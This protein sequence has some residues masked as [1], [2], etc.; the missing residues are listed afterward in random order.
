MTSDDF[1]INHA[2]KNVWCAPEQD[3]QHILR[4]ARI[5]P[6]VGARGSVEVLWTRFNLPTAKE[7]YHVFQ[8]GNIALS[9]LDLDLKRNVWTAVS[10]QMV[11]SV[12]LIDIYTEKGLMIPRRLAYFLYTNDGNLVIAIENLLTIGDFGQENVYVR[13]YSNAFFDRDDMNDPSEGI[14]YHYAK[15]LTSSAINALTFKL[16]DLRLKS[17]YS[18]A[19]VNGWRVNELNVSTVATGDMVEIVRDSSVVRVEEWDVKDLPVFLSELD[20]KQKYL[21]HPAVNED[22]LI[23]YRD[24]QD[25]F[26]MYKKTPYV[27]KGVYYHKNVEDSVR[28]VTHRDYSIPTAQVD[29]FLNQ[30]PNWAVNSQLTVQMFIRRSGIDRTLMSEAHHIRELYKLEGADWQAA[31]MGTEAVVD[32]WRIEELEKSQ[33]TALMRAPSATITREMVEAA[34]GYNTITRIVAD[35]PQKISTPKAWTELPFGLRGESTVY[36]YDGDGRLLGWY[37]NQ[38]VQNYVPRSA[39]ARYIE[40]IV[41]RGGEVLST[42][43]GKNAKIKAGLTYRCYV[44][45]IENGL[46]NSEWIDVT[47][48]TTHYDL[49]EGEVVWKVN[50]QMFYTAVKFDDTF[51]TYNLELDYADGLL[52]FSLNVKEIRI[53]G[54]LYEGLVEI[55]AGLLE[56][57]L[58]GCP[59][60]EKLDW[61]MVDKEIMIVNKQY[62]NQVGTKNII[63]IRHTGF[64]TPDMKRVKESEYGFVENGLLSRNNRWNLRDDKVVRVIADGRIWSREELSW[65]EDRPEVILKN[66]RNGAPYQVTEPLIP[67]RGLTYQD[68]YDMRE[69]AEATDKQIEDYMTV[70]VGEVPPQ[71]VNLIPY[72][73]TLYSPFVGKL[74]HDL[75]SGYFDQIPLTEYYSDVDVRKWCEGYDW[76]LKYEPT[77]KDFDER[78][79]SISAHERNEVFRLPIYQYNFLARAIRVMLDDKIDITNAIVIDHLPID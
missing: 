12:L 62:R 56:I 34:Y 77:T 19:F 49:I 48:K 25:I 67:L 78:Y 6:K 28:M 4:P 41:G 65:A 59:L 1:L 74:M 53:D 26:L 29:R 57:W 43:Y 23:W 32:V 37:L 64:C 73:H 5:S 71:E 40:G 20:Q 70:R 30:N 9:N 35:T 17:G 51:L 66:V 47:D 21:L 44:C 22:D 14:E 3:R 60:I 2:Y 50:P 58:N 27:H 75:I 76:L 54:V 55:P 7:R 42:V 11:E 8:F 68:A 24:D 39:A 46:P 18:F 79:V 13:F 69:V 61:F 31:I 63:T 52:R 33:Y 38:N 72:R 45:P 36:E 15:P 10:T 16:R